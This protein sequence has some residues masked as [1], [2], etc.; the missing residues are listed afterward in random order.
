VGTGDLVLE[1]L[2]AAREPVREVVLHERVLALGADTDPEAF[3]GLLERLAA[4]GHVRVSVD[5]ESVARDPDPFGPR[6]WSVKR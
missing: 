4:Q 1:A 2:R 5:H 3:I 6:Y